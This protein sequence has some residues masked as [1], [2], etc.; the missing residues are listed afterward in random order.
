MK[1][2]RLLKGIIALF[3]SILL[4]GCLNTGYAQDLPESASIADIN[5]LRDDIAHRTKQDIEAS[6]ALEEKR[7]LLALKTNVTERVNVLSMPAKPVD[8]DRYKTD[9]LDLV[10]RAINLDCNDGPRFRQ[11]TTD[12]YNLY[13]NMT[14]DLPVFD[15][16]D[17]KAK[18]KRIDDKFQTLPYEEECQQRI[19][20][21]KNSD[22][23]DDLDNLV[24]AQKKELER[25]STEKAQR[26]D[27]LLSLKKE[28]EIYDRKLDEAAQTANTKMSL[29]ANLYI[30]ILIIGL[31]SIATIGIVRWFPKDVMKEWVESGQVIQFVTVMILLSV[32]MALGLAGLLTENTLGTLLGGIGGYVLSQGVGR[33]AARA[34]MKQMNEGRNSRREEEPEE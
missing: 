22:I 24:E 25:I 31:L 29:Q 10:E 28:I 34:A 2:L 17:I 33:S 4:I 9:V 13:W 20:L 12:I 27:A 19:A 7:W 6:N 21:F 23:K 11:E 8:L 3:S 15:D 5:S 30:M 26:L 14:S 16:E 1:P 32:I 18:Q